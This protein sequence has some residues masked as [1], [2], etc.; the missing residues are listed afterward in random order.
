M[1]LAAIPFSR[2]NMQNSVPN[3]CPCWTGNMKLTRSSLPAPDFTWKPTLQARETGNC[4]LKQEKAIKVMPRRSPF[5]TNWSWG[6]WISA[7]RGSLSMIASMM[8]FT[9]STIL[10]S[11]PGS[12]CMESLSACLWDFQPVLPDPCCPVDY[13]FPAP[14]SMTWPMSVMILI[15]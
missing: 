15:P 9:S 12:W 8:S 5:S 3:C 6:V 2:L 14:C 1:V 11:I 7:M 4:P 13:N 10:L